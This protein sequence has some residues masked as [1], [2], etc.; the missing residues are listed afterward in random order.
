VTSE[1]KR[2]T[3]A[4]QEIVSIFKEGQVKGEKTGLT[5]E[6]AVIFVKDESERERTSNQSRRCESGISKGMTRTYAGTSIDQG[7]CGTSE[8]QLTNRE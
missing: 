7:Q 2:G 3:F 5:F 8:K 1:E 6:N 4:I